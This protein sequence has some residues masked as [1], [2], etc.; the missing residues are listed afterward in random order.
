MPIGASSMFDE[1]GGV[2]GARERMVNLTS[3]WF[4]RYRTWIPGLSGDFR[5]FYRIQG[6]SAEF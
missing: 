4:I 6:N 1:I 5:D 3:G 2:A